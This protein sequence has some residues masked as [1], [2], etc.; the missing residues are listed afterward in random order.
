MNGLKDSKHIDMDIDSIT[1]NLAGN[2]EIFHALLGNVTQ[3]EVIWKPDPNKWC[4]LEVV[5]HL[6]DEEREDFRARV[7]HLLRNPG[8]APPLFDQLAWITER[9]YM[10]QDYHKS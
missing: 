10:E 3:E 4:L 5:C 6:Y 7:E 2:K 9:K 1:R 8:V